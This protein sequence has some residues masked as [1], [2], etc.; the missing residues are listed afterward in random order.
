MVCKKVV[1]KK[2]QEEAQNIWCLVSKASTG[3]GHVPGRHKCV[4]GVAPAYPHDWCAQGPKPK[5]TSQPLRHALSTAVLTAPA[6]TPSMGAP[7]PNG[8]I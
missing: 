4:P 6:T 3:S 5:G 1:K 2:S 8:R 7:F